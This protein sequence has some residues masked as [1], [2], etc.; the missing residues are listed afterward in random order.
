MDRL[1][2]I[3]GRPGFRHHSVR[4]ANAERLFEA[5]QQFHALEAADAQIAVERLVQRGPYGAAA[6]FVDQV[7]NDGEDLL[8]NGGVGGGARKSHGAFTDS[9]TLESSGLLE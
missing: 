7:R 1:D 6:Q 3:P 9:T 2:Q 5:E 4:Q 8:V